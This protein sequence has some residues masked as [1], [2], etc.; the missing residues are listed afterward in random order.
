MCGKTCRKTEEVDD[1]L[2]RCNGLRTTIDLRA[3]KGPNELHEVL[4]K[5]LDIRAGQFTDKLDSRLRWA[6]LGWEES[7]TKKIGSLLA[8]GF[9]G[10]LEHDAY[11][12]K[13]LW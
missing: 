12:A 9:V 10:G 2:S 6:A 1:S 11:L 5:L 8:T 4:L 3:S 13:N 7:T